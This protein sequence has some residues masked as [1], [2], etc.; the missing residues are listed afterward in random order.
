MPDLRSR[1]LSFHQNLRGKIALKPKCVIRTKEDLSLAYT[2]GVA[3]PCMEIQK[4]YRNIYRY[5]SKGNW[6]AIV[7]NGTAVLG[8]GDIG[9]GAG[10]PVMEGKAVLFKQFAGIDAFPIC[11][12]S[13]STDEIVNAVKIMEPSFGG[14]NLE[15]IK[16]P[17]CFE[18]EERLKRVMSIPVFHDDQHGTAIVVLAALMNALRIIRKSKEETRI[19]I[20]GAGSAGIAIAKLLLFSGFRNIT[21]ADKMGILC[22]GENW[23]NKVQAEMADVTDP[24]KIRGDLSAALRGADVFIGV[25]A[26][27]VLTKEMIKTMQ[28]GPV[29][30]ALANPNPEICP[31][32]AK[33]AG[34]RIVAT[35]RSDYPNQVNNLLAFPGIF[36]GAL[37]VG[38][39]EINM[40]MKVA[41]ARAIAMLVD[42]DKLSEEYIIPSAMD[43]RVSP[44]V[45]DFVAKVAIETGA[46]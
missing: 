16:A 41:A 32:D 12:N 19:V 43:Q 15:D 42:K 30:F 24:N 37:D 23:M 14:I 9:A 25:S 8:L 3:E 46:A 27:N 1:A 29:I 13:K 45:A 44:Q 22:P 26:P 21:M 17:E 20:N 35:G 6:V 36:R 5:T 39:K 34:A 40:E 31:G 38:A 11:L 7:T 28:K 2:P 10:L 33:D 18:I 4:D